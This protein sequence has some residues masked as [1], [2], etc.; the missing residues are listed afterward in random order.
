MV[1]G[2]LLFDELGGEIIV[3]L[4]IFWLFVMGGGDCC[5]LVLIINFCR[6]LDVDFGVGLVVEC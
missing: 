6:F 2:I 3:V 4:G 5:I 1:C